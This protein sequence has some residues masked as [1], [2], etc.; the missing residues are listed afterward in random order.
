[1]LPIHGRTD[2]YP[3]GPRGLDAVPRE[4]PRGTAL[5]ALVAFE[6]RV[7]SREFLTWLGFVVLL[8]LTIGFTASGTIMLVG[9][10]GMV[11]RTAPWAIAHAMAGVTAFGQVITAMTAATT[12]LRDVAGRTQGLIL[13]T[14][15]PWRTYLGGRFL[16]TLAV[17]LLIYTAIPLGLSLGAW[18]ATVATHGASD[19]LTVSSVIVPLVILVV[20]NVL[21]VTTA[22]FAA[23]ALS[24]GFTVIL[25]VGLG[26]IGCW[27]SGL[28]LVGAG[29]ALGA[30]LDPFGNAALTLATAD[31]DT[32]ARTTRAMPMTGLLLANRAL[33]L[34]LATLLGV[35]TLRWWRPREVGGAPDTRLTTTRRTKV[36]V[37]ALPVSRGA[38]SAQAFVAEL[39]FGWHW[40]ARERGFA[41]LLILALSNAVANGWSASGDP[42]ALVRALEFHAR[43]FAILIATIYA[44]E[45]VWRDRDTRTDELL[46][47]MP[48]SHTLRL[49]GRATGVALGLLALPM[50]LLVVATLLPLVAGTGAPATVC[51]TRWILGYGAPAFMG[52]LVVSIVVHRIV[53]HK[54]VAHL[55]LI[56]AWVIA[57][58]LG[59]EELARPWRVWG[60]CGA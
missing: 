34:A 57:I 22:F 36:V 51:A 45:L 55:A 13:A 23:G 59:A 8:L 54:T 37:R 49:T 32:A 20:P 7:Q 26:F 25:F 46:R 12:V 4:V 5:R 44:G 41:A 48:V 9:D 60:T 6:L 58:A 10:L 27:Q 40:V 38:T 33:W 50:L 52:L 3:N 15:L 1:M 35:G 28:Q 18:I 24:G 30:L 29:Q 17:L 43:L 53:D 11:P 47:A 2:R 56:S 16:G 19:P 14:P 31:W 39:R 21:V 42:T